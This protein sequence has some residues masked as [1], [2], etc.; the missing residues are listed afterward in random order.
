MR[1]K[2]HWARKSQQPVDMAWTVSR[3]NGTGRLLPD[4]TADKND[5]L[6]TDRVITYF[7]YEINQITDKANGG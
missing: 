3:E 6:I 5:N 2:I 7:K 4:C 1:T